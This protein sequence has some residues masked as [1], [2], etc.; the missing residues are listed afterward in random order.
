M[1]NRMRPF[2]M[3]DN[4]KL[5]EDF[6]R[7]FKFSRFEERKTFGDARNEAIEA[8]CALHGGS[9]HDH[10]EVFDNALRDLCMNH[11]GL[12]GDDIRAEDN[13]WFQHFEKGNL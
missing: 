8:A 4:Q 2:Q 7:A 5:I 12:W 1:D 6:Q 9:I 3:S 13:R 11:R 10:A